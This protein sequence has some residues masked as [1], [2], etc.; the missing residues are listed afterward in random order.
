VLQKAPV[1]YQLIDGVR[2]TVTARYVLQ[3]QR[4]SIELGRYDTTKEL[5][6][7]PVLHYSTYLG[8]SGDDAGYE[9]AVDAAGHAYVVGTT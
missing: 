9:V 8:G 7:D 1:A 5:C 6:V 3:G 4:V 2:Q